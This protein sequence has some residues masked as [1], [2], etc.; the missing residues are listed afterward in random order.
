M[1]QDVEGVVMPIASNTD[2]TQALA[3][4]QA[5]LQGRCSVLQSA[6]W[7]SVS[8]HCDAR[9]LAILHTT[10]PKSTIP[11]IESRPQSLKSVSKSHTDQAGVCHG[12]DICVPLEPL[13]GIETI[14]Q[15]AHTT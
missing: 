12:A 7:A 5:C 10:I 2:A 11:S 13:T 3:C 8:G 9:R 14:V 4:C 15:A 1:V 6:A